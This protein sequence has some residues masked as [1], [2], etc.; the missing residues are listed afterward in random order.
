MPLIASRALSS[1]RGHSDTDAPLWAQS[2]AGGESDVSVCK[3]VPDQ[4]APGIEERTPAA[5]PP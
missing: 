2:R 3:V 5:T 1:V 4:M